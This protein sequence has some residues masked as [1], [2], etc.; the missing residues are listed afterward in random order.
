MAVN[1]PRRATSRARG[2]DQICAE[3]ALVD[4]FAALGDQARLEML[5]ALANGE[6]LDVATLATRASLSV[7]NTSQHLARLRR[8]G[9]VTS[10][11]TGTRVISRI[12]PELFEVLDSTNALLDDTNRTRL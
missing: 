10:R 5:I 7:P 1:Q 6:D 12:D 9:I 4:A 8:A 11:H 2:P 3:E